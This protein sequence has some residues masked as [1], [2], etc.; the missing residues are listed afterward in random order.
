MHKQ[1]NDDLK[2]RYKFKKF[3]IIRQLTVV[4]FPVYFYRI[5]TDEIFEI[6]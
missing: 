2:A 3:K 4:A 6:E 5:E 1:N